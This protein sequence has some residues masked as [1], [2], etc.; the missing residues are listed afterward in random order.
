MRL[1]SPVADSEDMNVST[2]VNASS[3]SG[4]QQMTNVNQVQY[5]PSKMYTEQH[6]N[7]PIQQQTSFS[8]PNITNQMNADVSQNISFG[9]SSMDNSIMDHPKKRLLKD[10]SMQMGGNNNNGRPFGGRRIP[11]NYDK[12]QPTHH[13]TV[14]YNQ[15]L[16]QN[17]PQQQQHNMASSNFMTPNTN[18]INASQT[19][20]IHLSHSSPIIQTTTNYLAQ[21]NNA[22]NLS[23]ASVMQQQQ[24]MINFQQQQHQQQQ[25]IAQARQTSTQIANMNLLTSTN[26]KPSQS[27]QSLINLLT[28]KSP[29]TGDTSGSM[30]SLPEATSYKSTSA[31]HQSFAY[32]PYPSQKSHKVSGAVYAQL[33]PSHISAMTSMNDQQQQLSAKEMYRSK[34]LPLNSTLQLPAPL[35][36]SVSGAGTFAVPRSATTLKANRVRTRSNSV[37]IKPPQ[38]QMMQSATSEPVLSTLAQ[39]LTTTNSKGFPLIISI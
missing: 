21:S 19:Q 18:Y 8:N 25:T 37:V 30:D 34:S 36:E 20:N 2:M 39:L 10:R 11:H 12:T 7:M 4:T 32:K 14:I 38:M 28:A 3:S 33:S 17:Q 22:L 1:F 13:Q 27:S 26:N 16:S 15:V 6:Q 9:Q 31:V 23:N 24:Q 35:K 29:S 5:Q